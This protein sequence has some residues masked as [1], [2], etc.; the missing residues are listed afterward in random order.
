MVNKMIYKNDIPEIINDLKSN[1]DALLNNLMHTYLELFM[2]EH[3]ECNHFAK[4]MEIILFKNVYDDLLDKFGG[5]RIFADKILSDSGLITISLVRGI[6]MLPNETPGDIVFIERSSD[7]IKIDDI[8]DGY[9]CIFKRS[10]SHRVIEIRDRKIITKGD[11]NKNRDLITTD[12]I[13]GKQILSIKRNTEFW[14]FL[15]K[16]LK[17]EKK[18]IECLDYTLECINNL[19]DVSEMELKEKENIQILLE[20]LKSDGND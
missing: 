3:E 5:N 13:F 7:D 4:E 1:K 18:L 12:T 19:D 11:N 14:K 2:I 15:I 8:I 16:K 17:L 10:L 6:S 20:N 9:E